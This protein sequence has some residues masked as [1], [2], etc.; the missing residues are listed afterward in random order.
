MS[1]PF[2]GE[3]KLVPY[4]FAPVGWAFCAG[5]LL[6]IDQNAVLFTLIGT[7]YG[8]DGQV[9]FALPDL[10][11]RA[12]VHLGQGPGLSNYVQGQTGGVEN[13]TLTAGQL[14]AH[15]HGVAVSS[16]LGNH[17]DPTGEHLASSPMGIG[18]A[19]GGSPNT[20]MAQ[21]TTVSGN[22]LP[23]EN[24][25]PYLVLNYIIALEG[26]FPPRP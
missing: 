13:V 11:G 8:G 4:N 12:A 21:G 20:T 22:S 5:Q 6:P 2:V 3:V 15:S 18:F 9:T 25:Q 19:Y 7:T 24:R 10:R 1:Q 14:P 23:H 16:N 26:V 17:S